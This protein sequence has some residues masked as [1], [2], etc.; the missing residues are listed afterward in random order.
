MNDFVIVLRG[1]RMYFS[2]F[3]TAIDTYN[4]ILDRS[5]ILYVMGNK[6]HQVKQYKNKIISIS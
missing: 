5:K 2:D 6:Y 1:T 4:K 3:K